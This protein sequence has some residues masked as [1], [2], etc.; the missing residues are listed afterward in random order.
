[1]PL[2]LLHVKSDNPI[3]KN[4]HQNVKSPTCL[5]ILW[6]LD[7]W[8]SIFFNNMMIFLCNARVMNHRLITSRS[9]EFTCTHGCC[10]S[11]KSRL[12]MRL[13]N[14]AQICRKMGKY[15]AFYNS[16]LECSSDGLSKGV[17]F[18]IRQRSFLL[19]KQIHTSVSTLP[20]RGGKKKMRSFKYF[21]SR[22]KKNSKP[23]I[24]T[25]LQNRTTNFEC[26]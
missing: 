22:Q 6:K 7:E 9:R 17:R 13:N 14:P 2:C 3:K 21:L 26:V 15:L 5:L 24:L 10:S 1:M 25:Y 12:P 19:E 8:L 20:R 4:K 23:K 11:W 18:V 16:P